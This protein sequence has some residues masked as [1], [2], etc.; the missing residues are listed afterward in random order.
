VSKGRVLVTV[1]VPAA[2]R[3]SG[4]GKDLKTVYKRPGKAKKVT[5]SVPLSRAG[6]KALSAR[7]RLSVRVRIGFIPKAKGKS[8]K[9]TS[10]VVFK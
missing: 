10:T 6:L 5:L 3:V 8:S 1:K 2:G 9:A 7:G 4:G